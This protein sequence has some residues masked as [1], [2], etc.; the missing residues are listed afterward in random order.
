MPCSPQLPALQCLYSV[1]L[2]MTI[3]EIH[4]LFSKA[5]PCTCILIPLPLTYFRAR[6]LGNAP[7]YIISCLLTKALFSSVCKHALTS[8]YLASFPLPSFSLQLAANFFAVFCYKPLLK[9]DL[10][11]LSLITLLPFALNYSN[12]AL[13]EMFVSGL[14]WSPC[15]YILQSVLSQSSS[16]LTQQQHFTQL[17]FFYVPDVFS[18][19]GFQNSTIPWFSFYSTCIFIDRFICSFSPFSLT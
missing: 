3:D 8:L 5:D 15:R 9:T 18:F 13:L 10:C 19:F 4:T 17:G 2:P 1:F 14:K 7:P 11:S 16:Y 6:L 12:E